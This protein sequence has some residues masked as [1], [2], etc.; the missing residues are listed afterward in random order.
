MIPGAIYGF[1]AGIQKAIISTYN[2]R[3]L[4]AVFVISCMYG[5]I[6]CV[7]WLKDLLAIIFKKFKVP[8]VLKEK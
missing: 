1:D 3:V 2:T 5:V 8:V 6:V 4:N 7:S